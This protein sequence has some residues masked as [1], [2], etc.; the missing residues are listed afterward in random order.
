MSKEILS[1]PEDFW[2]TF[3]IT[4]RINK[5]TI[6]WKRFNSQNFSSTFCLARFQ[7]MIDR[8]VIGLIIHLFITFVEYPF[9]KNSFALHFCKCSPLAADFF[10][11]LSLVSGRTDPTTLLCDNL[12]FHFSLYQLFSSIKFLHLFKA[13]WKTVRSI[14]TFGRQF[15]KRNKNSFPEEIQRSIFIHKRPFCYFFSHFKTPN[16]N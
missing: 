14:Q 9:R 11:F 3:T 2:G 4:N 7:M 5:L 1:S 12:Q 6:F 13:V 8:L 15:N 16:C 10:D